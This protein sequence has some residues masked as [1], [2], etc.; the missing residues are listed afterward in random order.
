MIDENILRRNA[1]IAE[2]ILCNAKLLREEV[3]QWEVMSKYESAVLQRVFFLVQADARLVDSSG[4]QFPVHGYLLKLL[5]PVFRGIK[6][7]G[8]SYHDWLL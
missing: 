1:K 7:K 2:N 4:E 3:S 8:P 5:F 6:E